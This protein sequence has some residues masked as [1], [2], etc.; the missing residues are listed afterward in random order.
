MKSLPLAVAAVSGLL[1]ASVPSLLQRQRSGPATEQPYRV[2]M[3]NFI[4]A[5]DSWKAADKFGDFRDLS[6]VLNALSREGW[7]TLQVF[8]A[9]TKLDE[10][11]VHY[12]FMVVAY[13]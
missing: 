4:R 2:V 13:R 3:T 10:A 6:D 8:P 12:Q 11:Y 9:P 1:V 5:K 7:R